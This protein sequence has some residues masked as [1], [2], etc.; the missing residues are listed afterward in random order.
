MGRRTVSQGIPHTDPSGARV[1][2]LV[3]VPKAILRYYDRVAGHGTS[4]DRLR[5]LRRGLRLNMFSL[6]DNF[7]RDGNRRNHSHR[8]GHTSPIV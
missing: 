1:G 6:D 4:N 5:R 8:S 7:L 3:D 2:P